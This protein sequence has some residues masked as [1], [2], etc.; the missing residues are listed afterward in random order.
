MAYATVQDFE[1]Y[2]APDALPSA[3][4]RLLERASTIVDEMVIG[5]VYSVDDEDMPTEP[6]VLAAFKSATLAQA[7]YMTVAGDETN[8]LQGFISVTQGSVSYSRATSSSGTNSS[9]TGSRY[10]S[11][12]Y[13]ILRVAGLLPVTPYLI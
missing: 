1:D 10:S 8:A 6:K 5:A 11:D 3:S 12:A 4:G 7:H 13:G 2:L 9:A